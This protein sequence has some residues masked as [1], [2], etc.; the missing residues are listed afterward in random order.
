[1]KDP[2][3]IY[4]NAGFYD[5][6]LTAITDQGCAGT[7]TKTI[8][9]GREPKSKFE[10]SAICNND[11]TR[12]VDKS[13]SGF[14]NIVQYE[15]DFGDGNVITG[16]GAATVNEM[17]TSGTYQNPNHKYIVNDKYPVKL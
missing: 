4:T 13:V 5:V 2:S 1:Q 3:N 15:W 11:S 6:E 8:R 14:S 12:F 7:A 16:A 17:Q 9:V 10:W